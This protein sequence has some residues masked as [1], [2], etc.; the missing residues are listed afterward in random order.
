[1]PIKFTQTVNEGSSCRLQ[2]QLVD[3]DGTGISSSNITTATFTL[4]NQ[5]GGA[6][7]NERNSV[8]VKSDFDTSGN[9]SRILNNLDNDIQDANL[10]LDKDNYEVHVAIFEIVA[11]SGGN[12][13]H[14]TEEIWIKVVSLE[15]LA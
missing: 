12:E 10:Y 4:R 1:M 9:F 14:L 2:F 3:F 13:V 11:T 8:D 6:I 15:K 7:I 5:K